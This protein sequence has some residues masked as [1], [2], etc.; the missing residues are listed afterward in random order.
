MNLAA[1]SVTSLFTAIADRIGLLT[2]D[3]P[4]GW[5]SLLMPAL[6]GA[7]AALAAAFVLR[8]YF[9]SGYRTAR[10]IVRHGIAATTVLGLLAFVAY[11]IRHAGFASRGINP[12]K[13]E[14]EFE[15]RKPKTTGTALVDARIELQANRNTTL[16]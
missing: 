2:N 16:A 12:P 7:A 3:S 14:V 11:D 4:D 15:V 8:V 1:S 10:D 6:A 13:P 9:R 5:S